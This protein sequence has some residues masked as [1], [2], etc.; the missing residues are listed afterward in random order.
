MQARNLVRSWIQASRTLHRADEI[1][2][3]DETGHK[4]KIEAPLDD[5]ITRAV[6]PQ[7]AP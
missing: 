4:R 6:R 2:K 7:A 1:R 3:Q 5:T